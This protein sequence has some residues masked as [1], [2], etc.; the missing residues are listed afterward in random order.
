MLVSV[1]ERPTQSSVSTATSLSS[2]FP[3][4]HASVPSCLW[5]TAAQCLD[6][7]VPVLCLPQTHRTLVPVTVH[8]VQ[9]N[10]YWEAAQW[11]PQAPL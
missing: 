3:L 11:D 10:L 2:T 8:V 7:R 5:R 4:G 9:P 1:S 6:M